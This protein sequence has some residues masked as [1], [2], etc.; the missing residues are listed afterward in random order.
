MP[1]F[2]RKIVVVEARQL[3]IN[4]IHEL[5]RWSKGS[6]KGTRL[7]IEQQ[8]VDIQTNS[9]E[10]RADIGDWIILGPTGEF[11]PCK[12]DIFELVYENV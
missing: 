5:E 10:Q 7:P 4:N 11:Y 2:R 9:G 6:I 12:A 1:L 3:T 8:V